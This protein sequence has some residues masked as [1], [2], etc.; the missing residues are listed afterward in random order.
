MNCVPNRI[1]PS[2][3]RTVSHSLGLG[4]FFYF[5][6]HLQNDNSWTFLFMASAPSRRGQRCSGALR[7]AG[8]EQKKWVLNWLGGGTAGCH[9]CNEIRLVCIQMTRN[10]V[11]F[12]PESSP[13][14]VVVIILHFHPW[15]YGTTATPPPPSCGI[16]VFQSFSPVQS[17]NNI[18]GQSTCKMRFVTFELGINGQLIIRWLV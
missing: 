10:Y 1:A 14:I 9:C 13:T 16:V 2:L 11:R 7:S 8:I 5:F 18:F 4:F 6:F 17:G 3:D 15:F 12:Y